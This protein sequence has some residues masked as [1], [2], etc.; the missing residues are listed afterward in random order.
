MNDE[1]NDDSVATLI[2]AAGKRPQPSAELMERVRASVHDE[3]REVVSR[4]RRT[5]WTLAAVAAIALLAIAIGTL[6]PRN[7]Q[8]AI[9]ATTAEPR[10]IEWTGNTL[11]VGRDSRVVLVS[12]VVARLERGTLYVSRT[13]GPRVTIRTPFGDVH[14]IGTMFAL[15]LSNDR[16]EVRVDEGIVTLRNASANAG[17]VL[18]A[19]RDRIEKSMRLEGLRL[20]DVLQRIAREKHLTLDWHAP[21]AAR[22]V[23]LH[24][25][26]LLTIDESLDA[27]TA[28][29]SVRTHVED[30]RL[31]VEERR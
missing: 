23:R 24:G 1:M 22:A 27:A 7:S 9:I 16:L 4:R 29:A 25:D 28:A 30:G 3:W 18:V 6:V 5:R 15:D 26:T 14:D 10:S 8:P 19:T 20:D 17:D 12:D 13:S 11:R 2:R 31:V 21:S